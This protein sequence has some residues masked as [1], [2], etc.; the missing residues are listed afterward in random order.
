VQGANLLIT[1]Y[2]PDGTVKDA[3]PAAT[4]ENGISEFVFQVPDLYKVDQL[5]E[6]EVRV[7][8]LGSS[9]TTSTW[10]RIWW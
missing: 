2:F 10:F 9:T 1:L 5:I 3:R 4:N 8:Y 7:D 6:V